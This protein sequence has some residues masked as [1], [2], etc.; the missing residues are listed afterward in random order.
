MSQPDPQTTIRMRY[1]KEPDHT[2]NGYIFTNVAHARDWLTQK[3]VRPAEISLEEVA[4]GDL[5]RCRHCDGSGYKQSVRS[6]RKLSV[7]EFLRE[8]ADAE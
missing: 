6:V 1:H 7:G 2:S 3:F 4:V 8:R 5:V